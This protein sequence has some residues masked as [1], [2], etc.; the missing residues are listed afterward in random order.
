MRPFLQALL[1]ACL[2]GSATP[3]S[4]LLL[5][6]IGPYQLA[7]LLYLGAAL[8]VC[9]IVIWRWHRGRS[10]LPPDALNRRRLWGAVLFGGIIGPVLL[11]FGLR[12]ALASSVSMWLNLETV[13]TAI[14]AALIFRE[15]IGR[16][17]WTGNVGVVFAGILLG[18]Q[19]GWAGWLGLTCVAGA[20]LAWGIDNNLTATIDSISAEDI[21]FWKGLIAGAINLALG[22]AIEPSIPGLPWL[23]A[24]VVGG[25]A[26]GL[27]V[28][29][30]IRSAQ[31]MGASRSQMIFSA[32]PFFGVVLSATLLGEPMLG[33][34]WIA[35]GLLIASI[36]MIFLGRHDHL[37]E[38]ASMFHDHEHRHDDGHHDH[39]HPGLQPHQVHSHPHEHHVQRHAHPHWPDIHHRHH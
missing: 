26:Y 28:A 2:F 1:A 11:L 3:I 4:K 29:L 12:H 39:D 17:A 25:F 21:T 19:G 10:I 27:S 7:G 36:L 32:A 35:C 31:A 34:Q 15:H 18:Y 6:D 16:W 23:G 8:F 38:H 24:L 9:P 13:A 5:Q 14:L 20:A 30:Y 37:H 33:L 22:L